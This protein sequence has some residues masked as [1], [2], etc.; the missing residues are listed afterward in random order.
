MT[1]DIK[2][3][4][5]NT[6]PSVNRYVVVE[7]LLANAIDSYLIRRKEDLNIPKLSIF[8]EIDFIQNSLLE[9][10]EYDL[11]ISCSDNGAGF[12]NLQV[13]AFVTKDSTFKDYLQ[14][15]GIGKC[16]GAGR[17]Q[18]FH[19]FKSLNIDSNYLDEKILKRRKLYI[20][21]ETIEVSEA[22]FTQYD[23]ESK[24]IITKITV[25][26]IKKN[27]FKNF[28]DLSVRNDFSALS[29]RNYILTTFLQRF[30]LLKDIIGEF[31]I[32]FGEKNDNE[33]SF[34][35]SAVDLPIPVN[36]TTINLKCSQSNT[37]KPKYSLKI[38]RYSITSS[39]SIN[40][41]HEI[42][43]CANSAI[44]YS[45]TKKFFRTPSDIK[46]PIDGQFELILVESEFLEG[47]VNQQRDGF[48]I[49][50]DC[51]NGED[52]IDEISMQ[53]IIESLEEYVYSILT[54]KDFDRNAL[55][56]STQEKFGISR[57]ILEETNIKIHYSDTEENIAKRALKKLQD[58]IVKDTSNLFD[59][60][61]EVLE[62]DPR[63]ENFRAKI[64]DLSWKYT[65]TLKKMDMANLSQ[66]V[67]RRSSMIEVLSKAVK[68]MLACQEKSSDARREDEK[69]IHN[70][71][72]PTGKNNTEIIDHDIWLL[73]E[74]Y[75]Y[76]EHIASDKPL[77]SFTWKNNT[78]LFEPDI[79]ESLESLFRKYNK[80]HSKKR[81]DIAI[82]NDEGSAIIIE[83]KAPKEPLQEHI[84]DLVQYSRLLAA[85]SG[86]RIKKF[87][88]YLIG[89]TLDESRMPTAY[90]RFPSGD[91][92]FNSSPLFDP[93]TRMPYGELYSEILFYDQFITRA[94]NRLNI[95][96]KKL[97]IE[98]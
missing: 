41:Q 90:E 13:K 75:H 78:K 6:P 71:F 51:G 62:L 21:S 72:F 91:G 65:S 23:V 98:F 96:K 36:T 73:N 70:I 97:N 54:P 17:I 89:N 58:E 66:L 69:V 38:T 86:G 26:G 84:P 34:K 93:T 56:A 85:K 52:L 87:Y 7:E 9:D 53:D 47:K 11:N 19:Y 55:I 12:G 25:N 33:Q 18:F 24:D 43:L 15:E 31:S 79:D 44:V 63:S 59:M 4:L 57:T 64:N 22:H 1:L 68:L 28:N 20:N 27:A 40:L 10:G 37:I 88:G 48:N 3:G 82:F 92:Y 32:I 39:E 95:Y 49:P 2:G 14:I 94:E 42:A 5:K 45:L 81:P 60:K 8:F 80:D 83:F 61:Q 29:I 74:E 50:K 30:L 35:I 46:K 16:K 76:F 67:V 77:S